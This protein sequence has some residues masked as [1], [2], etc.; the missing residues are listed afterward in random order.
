MN[1]RPSTPGLLGA[2]GARRPRPLGPGARKGFTL[3]EIVIVLVILAATAALAVPR[4]APL[5]DREDMKAAARVLALA[6]ADAREQAMLRQEPWGLAVDLDDGVIWADR[7][8]ALDLTKSLQEL[9]ASGR[10]KSLPGGIR[11]ASVT[12]RERDPAQTGRIIIGFLP[13]GLAEP[14]AIALVAPDKT[15]R[16]L[17]LQSFNGRLVAV[18]DEKQARFLLGFLPEAKSGPAAVGP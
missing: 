11:V 9:R 15:K 17:A 3:A 8:A 1:R 14:C 13:M 6:A 4:L 7:L 12:R 2:P 10:T 16:L 5:L 18:D